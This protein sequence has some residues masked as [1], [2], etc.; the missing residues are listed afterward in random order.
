MVE[1]LLEN[2]IERSKVVAKIVAV[3]EGKKPVVRIPYR[4]ITTKRYLQMVTR[5]KRLHVDGDKEEVVIE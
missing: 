1:L 2:E 4:S 3:E 5:G